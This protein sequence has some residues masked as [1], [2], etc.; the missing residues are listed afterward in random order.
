M[1]PTLSW[2][3][4]FFWEN[5]PDPACS[6]SSKKL[7]SNHGSLW[8]SPFPFPPHGAGG[9]NEVDEASGLWKKG[10]CHVIC[11]QKEQSRTSDGYHGQQRAQ[12][13]LDKPVSESKVWGGAKES[14]GLYPAGHGHA[15]SIA[16]ARA[17]GCGRHLLSNGQTP[18]ARPVGGPSAT[19]TILP[20]VCCKV[21]WAT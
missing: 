12:W 1:Y 15:Y 21:K 8:M 10:C 20:A 19:Q 11:E 4:L 7:S 5:S 6:C 2:G 18:P 13:S 17:R 14:A 9:D 3:V 16:Q